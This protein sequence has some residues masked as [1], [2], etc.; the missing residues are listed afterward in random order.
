MEGTI[1]SASEY[2]W[3]HDLSLVGHLYAEILCRNAEIDTLLSLFG[4]VNNNFIFWQSIVKIIIYVYDSRCTII[5]DLQYEIQ[6]YFWL[7][8]SKLSDTYAFL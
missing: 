3:G 8:Y 1:S 4:E 2:C 6:L 5:P 7:F